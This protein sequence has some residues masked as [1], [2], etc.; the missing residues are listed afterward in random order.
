[1][2]RIRPNA[3]NPAARPADAGR[4]VVMRT[5]PAW[6][7][8][9][10]CGASSTLPSG[11]WPANLTPMEGSALNPAR[12]ACGPGRGV[13]ARDPRGTLYSSCIL[14]VFFLYSSCIPRLAQ[15]TPPLGSWIAKPAAVSTCFRRPG[16]GRHANTGLICRQIDPWI[17]GQGGAASPNRPDCGVFVLSASFFIIPVD[18]YAPI[19]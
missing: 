6:T 8:A 16:L 13:Q 10:A 15:G 11:A 4:R 5:D 14:P 17:R 18:S 9:T 2:T 7:R 3:G 1:M 19:V 12:G